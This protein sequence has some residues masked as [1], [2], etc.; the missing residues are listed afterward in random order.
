MESVMRELNEAAAAHERFRAVRRFGSLDAIRCLAITAVICRHASPFSGDWTPFTS[1]GA[2]GVSLFFALS[3]FLIT[4][5]LLREQ[6]SHGRIGLFDFY[7]RRALRIFPLYFAVLGLYAAITFLTERDAQG[8]LNGAARLFAQNLPY[9]ATYTNNWFVD[10]K[11]NEDGQRR[12]IFIF[13]WSLATEEQFY[14]FWPPLLAKCSRGFAIAVLT[15]VM[16]GAAALLL[17][18]KPVEVPTT[19][20]ERLIRIGQSPSPEICMGVL[21]ALVLHSRTGFERAWRVLG[22]R[23]SSLIF[24]IPVLVVICFP[25]QD[26][27]PWY[28]VQG[29]VFVLWLGSCVIREDHALARV[30]TLPPLARVGVVSYGMYLLHMLSYNAV[31]VAS[32]RVGVESKPLMF[33]GTLLGAYVAAEISFRFFERPFLNLKARFATPSAHGAS[34]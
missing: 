14:A 4:T 20:L 10:L 24:A 8:H 13:A 25:C 11:L 3:G 9:Y 21:A 17:I 19:A 27:P 22:G 1:I 32:H 31:K 29:V 6:A 16:V 23:W 5:L 26:G 2:S 30:L 33:V 7:A 34:S 18:Y 15:L 12:V 28:L